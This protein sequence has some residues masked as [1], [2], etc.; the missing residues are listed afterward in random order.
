MYSRNTT[1]KPL[2]ERQVLK[3]ISLLSVNL[4]PA[5]LNLPVDP[6]VFFDLGYV[7]QINGGIYSS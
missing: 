1:Y 7:Q 5:L 2:V 4:H 6:G 3:A